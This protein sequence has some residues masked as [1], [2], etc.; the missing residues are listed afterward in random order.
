VLKSAL[1]GT[2]LNNNMNGSL[3]F[4]AQTQQ[5]TQTIVP[6]GT[7]T[8]SA[9]LNF[10]AAPYFTLT[11]GGSITLAF[12]NI[13]PAMSTTTSQPIISTWAVAITVASTAHIVTLPTAVTQNAQGIQGF[14]T[15]TN[16]ITFA[17]TGTY[18]FAFSTTDG[19]STVAINEVNKQLQPFNNSSESLASAGAANLA[20]TTS[21][22]STNGT[23]TLAAGVAGQI[24]TFMQTV[25][26][27][28]MVVTVTNAGWKASGTGTITF[29]STT[30]GTGCTL[31]Y[32]NSKWY[33]IGNNGC[34]FA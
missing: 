10:A 7:I 23:A 30:I 12:S 9:I 1:T 18:V 15:S 34:S 4:N 14:N 13:P 33:C 19:G 27:T 8:S 6:L 26:T 17:A 29:P 31:Q 5:M 11:T 3:F 16:T 28:A 24:K 2:T 32:V 25:S 22:F 21:Y 20:L